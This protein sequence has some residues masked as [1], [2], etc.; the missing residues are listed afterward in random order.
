MLT[1]P[2]L[3]PIP[4]SS[5][6]EYIVA[7]IYTVILPVSRLTLQ[8]K[9]GYCTDGASTGAAQYL[10]FNPFDPSTM[11][12]ALCHD[13]LYEGELFGHDDGARTAADNEFYALLKLNGQHSASV[14]WLYYKA[15]RWF[16][17]FVWRRHSLQSITDAR[18]FV[19]LV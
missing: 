2:E 10:G 6:E 17:G 16:G 14:A 8:I 9:P 4:D 19:S 12:P 13:A 18:R 11:A 7:D 3:T 5:P 15:V 1:Q